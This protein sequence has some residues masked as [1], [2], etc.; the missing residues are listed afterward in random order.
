MLQSA[1]LF[2]GVVALLMSGVAILTPDEGIAIVSGV[3]GFIAWGLIAYGSFDIRVVG[4]STVY[5]FTQPSVALFG[6]MMALIPGYIAL[7]G[8]INIIQRAKDTQLDEV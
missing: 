3:V 6:I 4:D 5:S 1:F 7:T 8:P 2:V